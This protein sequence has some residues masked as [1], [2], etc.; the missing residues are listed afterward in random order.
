MEDSDKSRL[1]AYQ[2]LQT[3]IE[4]DDS[5]YEEVERLTKELKQVGNADDA[6]V[7]DQIL[8]VAALRKGHSQA[9]L[10]KLEQEKTKEPFLYVYALHTLGKQSSA[11]TNI[12]SLSVDKSEYYASMLYAQIL[13]KLDQKEKSSEVFE[14]ILK[15]NDSKLEQDMNELLTNLLA[16]YTNMSGVDEGHIK[17]IDQKITGEVS[18]DLVF[19]SA[20]AYAGLERQEK[21]AAKKLKESYEIARESG[22]SDSSKFPILATYIA[23]KLLSRATNV[24]DFSFSDLK[25]DAS[26]PEKFESTENETAYFNNV[27]CIQSHFNDTDVDLNRLASK[28]SNVLKSKAKDINQHQKETF[29]LNLLNISLRKN[30]VSEVRKL[31]GDLEKSEIEFSDQF[32]NRLRIAALLL[33]NKFDEALEK[34]K[35][36]SGTFEAL[37]RAQIQISSGKIQQGIRDLIQYCQEQQVSNSRLLSFLLKACIDGKFTEE[38]QMIVNLAI[39][40]INSLPKDV[41]SLIGHILIEDQNFSQAYEVFDKI[42]DTTDDSRI[43]AGYLSA[44]AERDTK[45]A[46]E[47]FNSLHFS[48]PEMETEEDI[49]DL[50]EEPLATKKTEKKRDKKEVEKIEDTKY[51]GKIF[52]PKVKAKKNIK[53]PKNFDPEN[54]GPLPDPERWIPKWQRS[55]GRKKLNRMKGPQGDVRNIGMHQKKEHTTANIEAAT[56]GAGGRRKK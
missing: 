13:Y 41:L 38:K 26:G 29:F 2:K 31:I 34:V 54:P 42:K 11:L 40:N 9:M 18:S 46:A 30:K 51:G 17:N 33:E 4:D 21:T 47:Y 7:C 27:A 53:Y 23:A 28:I 12:D 19:N 32:V 52:I 39:Q 25:I 8:K 44:L 5:S 56:A 50:L 6:K 14:D 37:C 20:A 49:H 15:S 48:L 16:A 3:A 43:K 45:A 1:E 10:N 24:T 35:N 55:K 22:E 36:P